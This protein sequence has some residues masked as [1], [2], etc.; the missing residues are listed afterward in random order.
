MKNRLYDYICIFVVLEILQSSICYAKIISDTRRTKREISVAETSQLKEDINYAKEINLQHEEKSDND[1]EEDGTYQDDTSKKRKISKKAAN[2]MSSTDFCPS[3]AEESFNRDNVSSYL[4]LQRSN[5]DLETEE[6]TKQERDKNE[7]ASN[8]IRL[9]RNI[10]DD[11]NRYTDQNERSSLYD[12]YEAKDIAKRGI[13]SGSEDYEEMEDDLPG[14]EDMAAVQELTNEA[15]KRETQ[16]DARVKRDQAEISEMLDKSR[17]NLDNPAKLEESKIVEKNPYSREVFHTEL[18]KSFNEA[19]APNTIKDFES[20]DVI[21]KLSGSSKI[22]EP[23][24]I[25]APLKKDE[26]NAEYEKRVEEEI[27]RKID[28]IKEEIKRDIE[29]Q[30]RIRDIENNNAR[31]DELQD[32]EHEDEERQNFENESIKKRQTVAKK[33]VQE[34]ADDEKSSSPEKSEEK[35]SLKKEQHKKRQHRSNKIST[36]D[37]SKQNE[38][39][40]RQVVAD[41]DKPSEQVPSKELFKKKRERVRQIFLVNNDQHQTKRRQLRSYSLPSAQAVVRSEDELFM[42]PKLNSYLRTDNRMFEKS[43]PVGSE[44]ENNEEE[45]SPTAEQSDSLVSLIGSSQELSPCLEKEYKEAFGGLQSEPG[46][47]LARFKRVKRVL[48]NDPN[49][50]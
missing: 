46:N 30:Q 43:L 48:T 9:P 17:S 28:F 6:A 22:Q 12:D 41:Y 42:N 24:S 26:L 10:N 15:E 21:S 33:S 29:V 44:D 32:Q 47:A 19:S 20:K 38:N 40:K 36:S 25:V 34:I 3:K 35:R 4:N 14:I 23:A 5:E 39:L 8:F 45:Q 49:A 27:Q 37:T 1:L 13:L 11:F 7:K 2:F 31:F 50:I 18:S 16:K